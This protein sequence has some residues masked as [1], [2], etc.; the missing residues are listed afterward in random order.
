MKVVERFQIEPEICAY[1]GDRPSVIEYA[2][3]SELT[4][5][6]YEDLMNTGWR[7]F[8]PLLF[9]PICREC[10]ECRPIRVAVESFKPSRSQQRNRRDNADLDVRVVLPEATE[11]RVEL[12]N[13]YHRWRQRSRGWPETSMGL[14]EYQALAVNNPIR[15]GE[16]LLRHRGKLI[17][18]MQLDF[19]THVVSDV[20]HFYDPAYASRGLGTF[21]ILQTLELARRQQKPWVYLGYHVVGSRS[22]EYKTRYRPY[23]I[24]DQEGVW[25]G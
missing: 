17:G 19:T 7:K 8:G 23:E 6:E 16:I 14:M 24:L 10:R 25:R 3:V 12:Y 2:L 22:M 18:V 1:L 9:H 15:G 5:A 21:L 4:A 20:Y 13:S 11:E